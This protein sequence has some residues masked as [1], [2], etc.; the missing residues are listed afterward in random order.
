MN[1][2]M[3]E[4][5]GPAEQY[6]LPLQ[7]L[8][9]RQRAAFMAELPVTAATRID[10]LRRLGEL[11]I[12]GRDALC[13]AMQTDFGTRSRHVSLLTDIVFSLRNIN[14]ARKHVETW[15][16][17]SRRPLDFPLRLLGSDAWVEFQPKGVVGIL[18][19]WNFPVY[20]TLTPLAGVLAAGNRAM[21]KPS[22]LTP[23]T[24]TC[25]AALIS[26]HFDE[27]EVA[28]TLGDATVGAAFSSLPFDHLVFTGGGAVGRHVMLAAADKLV[29]VTLELGGKSPVIV[30][31]SADI[32]AAAERI[33]LGKLLNAGQIC[34]A[35]DYVLVARELEEPLVQAMLAQAR[36]LYPCYAGNP[37]YV[38]IVNAR[39]HARL[40]S[41]L[42][43]ARKRGAS[44]VS[45]DVD[46]T[47]G[48][49]NP[50]T[51]IMPFTIVR[52]APHD[53]AILGNEIF[54]PLLPVIPFER[55]E[56]AVRHINDRDRPL[57]LYYFGRDNSEQQIV[58]SR[59]IA[60]GVTLNDVIFHVMQEDLPLGGIGG[61]GMGRYHGREGFLEF[62]HPKAVY[63]QTRFDIA[64]LLGS[65]PPYGKKLDAYI[66]KE[67]KL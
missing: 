62:S 34:L 11:L 47:E 44:I 6:G 29:P 7:Q 5:R 38:A 10:R 36:R 15:M 66:R 21:I 19:P 18:S 32:E 63:K 52:N 42:D 67:L 26:Q 61:S 50:A 60:G 57:G 49:A 41:Y 37:D 40:Q 56:D 8:L 54:G 43:D 1:A 31:R 59:T 27:T 14:H 51:R 35:P 30:G 17:R 25:M 9:D 23:A 55:I 16:K 46:G 64:A 39:H 65:K 20:L 2:S 45:A 28:V 48:Q 12:A 33:V 24:S 13:D 53:S 4:G 3:K 22:E 58:L